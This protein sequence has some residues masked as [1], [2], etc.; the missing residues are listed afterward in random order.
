MFSRRAFITTPCY[1]ESHFVTPLLCNCYSTCRHNTVSFRNN[2]H[3][4]TTR[5]IPR[6]VAKTEESQA[7][8]GAGD[9]NN[10]AG[11]R[12]SENVRRPL[13]LMMCRL[14]RISKCLLP[15]P[16]SRLHPPLEHKELCRLRRNDRPG[17]SVGLYK[18]PDKCW[19]MEGKVNI[20]FHECSI[21]LSCRD[22]SLFMSTG[23]VRFNNAEDAFWE[24][25]LQSGIVFVGL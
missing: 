10:A 20:L 19:E 2:L 6:H 25:A 8:E 18:Y 3:S 16:P 23:I 9:N 15:P 21:Q 13:P 24:I 17:M 4:K 14:L 11:E 5:T 12:F 1:E 7:Y 22:E